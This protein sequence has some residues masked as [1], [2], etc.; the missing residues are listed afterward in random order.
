MQRRR[1]LTGAALAAAGCAMPPSPG[2][3]RSAEAFKTVRYFTAPDGVRIPFRDSGQAGVPAFL[4]CNGG[5]QAMAVWSSIADPLAASY[6]VIL[7]DRRGTG[8]S[9]PGAPETHSFTTFR[10][11]AVGVM[12]AAGVRTAVVCGLA[13]GSRV[14]LRM[15]LDVPERLTGLILFDATGG[16]AAPEAERRAGAEEA[17]RLR[18]AAGIPTP[19]RDPAWTA[20][21]TPNGPALNGRALQGQ[22]AWI[23]GLSQ[24]RMPTLIAVGE[25]DPNL[26]GGRRLAREIAN[27]RFEAMP[28]TGHGS[29]VQRPDLLLALIRG[30]IG[31]I[32]A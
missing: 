4:F 27:A 8:E 32:S 24:L 23:E 11:D 25:Q 5:G 20:T 13:F 18:T 14:A 28:M 26:E 10:N 31:E 22:P 19:E 6:R 9:D 7:H 2:A 12:D 17:A 29:N 30:F 1:F 16:P 3:P 21:K 15:A